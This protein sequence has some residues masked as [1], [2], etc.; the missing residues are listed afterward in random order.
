MHMLPNT[1]VVHA[2]GQFDRSVK[3][4]FGTSA[5]W[6]RQTAVSGAKPIKK[7]AA[8]QRFHRDGRFVNHCDGRVVPAGLGVRR[9]VQIRPE[10]PYLSFETMGEKHGL[11]TK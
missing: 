5:R 6:H 8:V 2:A 3:L 9:E 4:A 11:F 7:A 10:H 1:R